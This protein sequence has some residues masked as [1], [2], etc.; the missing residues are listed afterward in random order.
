LGQAP[1]DTHE[2]VAVLG[3][4]LAADVAAALEA[5]R[6]PGRWGQAGSRIQVVGGGE[7]VDGQAVGGEAGRPHRC[8]AGQG[9]EDLARSGCQQPGQLGLDRGDVGLQALVVGQVTAESLGAQLGVDGGQQPPPAVDPEASGGPGEPTGRSGLKR[10][11]RR[12]PAGEGGRTGQY[13]LAGRIVQVKAA[14]MAG[15]GGQARAER[16]ELVMEALLEDLAVADQPRRWRTAPSRA[17]TVSV[18]AGRPVPWRTSQT[19]AAQSRSS[20]LERRQPSWA[21]AT[22]VS[23]GANSR[24]DPGQRRSSSATQAW[25]SR[26]VASTAMVGAPATPLAAISLARVSTPSRT[27]NDTGSPIRPRSPLASNTRLL[28]LPGSTATISAVAGTA[29]RNSSTTTSHL[30]TNR[31][32]PPCSGKSLTTQSRSGAISGRRPRAARR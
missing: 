18:A 26:P 3:Q 14:A 2:R 16:L 20:V 9:G 29:W 21:L 27:G 5:G 15:W 30:L 22:W 24:T 28:T 4:A 6:L 13:R 25:C 12:R 1:G 8:H 10:P 32:G 7:A 19:S 23:D 11:H 17:S 31:K